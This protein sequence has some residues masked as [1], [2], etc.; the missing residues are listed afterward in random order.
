MRF[1]IDYE[2]VN[3]RGFR[4][5]DL[6]SP[7]D[8]VLLFYS[9]NT[10]TIRMRVFERLVNSVFK[11]TLVRVPDIFIKPGIK[12]TLDFFLIARLFSD[13]SNKETDV[14]IVSDDK[15][16]D[17]AIDAA[18]INGFNKVGRIPIVQCAFN[19]QEYDP[20]EDVYGLDDSDIPEAVVTAP[21]NEHNTAN[22][23]NDESYE[24]DLPE[25]DE[26]DLSWLAQY[27]RELDEMDAEEYEAMELE[28]D[29]PFKKPAVGVE[30]KGTNTEREEKK[31]K[32]RQILSHDLTDEEYQNCGQTIVDCI[33]LSASKG[34]QG[35]E[36]F[37]HLM[38]SRFGKK[39]GGGLYKKVRDDYP[40][41]AQCCELSSIN[42]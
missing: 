19:D 14:F 13:E 4:G 32:V 29:P 10:Q 16:Y 23:E 40:I 37:Y 18:R 8:E 33:H 26:T 25:N 22:N 38:L 1:Y 34:K 30:K 28:D 27:G 35:K 11:L 12:N 36:Q 17:C 20:Q 7:E 39:V 15:G 6:L 9:K 42:I 31:K 24:S 2:N 3:G 21:L 41:L 5:C